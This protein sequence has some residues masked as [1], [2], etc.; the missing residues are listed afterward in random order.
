MATHNFLWPAHVQCSDRT[1]L[2]E[3]QRAIRAA[4]AFRMPRGEAESARGPCEP[5]AEGCTRAAVTARASREQG[6]GVAQTAWGACA[7]SDDA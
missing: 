4:Q 1:D 2:G 3:A 7:A 5:R 6:A